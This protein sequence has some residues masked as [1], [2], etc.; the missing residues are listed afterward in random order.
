ML[1]LLSAVEV[2]RSYGITHRA[3]RADNVYYRDENREHI[4]LGD[5]IASFP[6]YHQ[7]AAAETIE[8]LMAQKDGR[9]NGSDKNDIYAVGALMLQFYLGHG[10]LEELTETEMLRLKL[11]KAAIKPCLMRIKLPPIT[12]VFSAVCSTIL[13]KTAGLTPIPTVLSK[14]NR[15]T[16]PKAP[17]SARKRH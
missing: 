3:I 15:S 9:G 11:K 1:S 16:S 4:V 8:S 14:A 12:P 13:K 7:P 6:A 17:S 5:C 10:L 2:L